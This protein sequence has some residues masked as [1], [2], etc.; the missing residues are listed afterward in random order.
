MLQFSRQNTPADALVLIIGSDAPVMRFFRTGLK[1]AGYATMTYLYGPGIGEIA[2][3]AR[4]NLIFLQLDAPDENDIT[5]FQELREKVTQECPIFVLAG[6]IHE[7]ALQKINATAFIQLPCNF[8]DVL[9]QVNSLIGHLNPHLS[10]P[11]KGFLYPADNPPPDL[12]EEFR[13]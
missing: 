13:R 11:R 8:D 2:R 10:R 1:Y 9:T 6:H 5:L 7:Q 4:P 3:S 12:P